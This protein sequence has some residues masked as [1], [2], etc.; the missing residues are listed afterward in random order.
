MSLLDRRTLL[1][2]LPLA[3]A[4]CGFTPVHG[5]GGN[6][7]ALYQQIEVQ[8]PEEVATASPA[9]AYLLV[10]SLEERLGRTGSGA[11]RLTLSLSTGSEG[12]AITADNELTRYSLVGSAGY[13]LT[14]ISDG[15][16]VSSG[17][18]ENFTAY[19]ATGS[20]VETL[21]GERDAHRR[22]MVI[23]AEQIAA[24]ILATA[25]VSAPAPA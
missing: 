25:D 1:L 11:Y 10:R 7:A 13:T 9:D 12:Q 22:L 24:R 20:T 3:A 2:A 17:T 21:A 18:A 19:S 6:G 14:R 4:A 8:A 23:L 15:K 5:P 16:V